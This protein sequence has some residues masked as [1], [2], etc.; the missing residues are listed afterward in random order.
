MILGIH[1][2][3][4][5]LLKVHKSCVHPGLRVTGSSKVRL[6]MVGALWLREVI[7]SS[8]ILVLHINVTDTQVTRLVNSQTIVFF[9]KRLFSFGCRFLTIFFDFLISILTNILV[10]YRRTI[11]HLR[12]WILPH[13]IISRSFHHLPLLDWTSHSAS[14]ITFIR[15]STSLA[16]RPILSIN[17]LS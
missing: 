11:D 6:I 12:L 2:L 3:L 15:F 4:M 14:L 7:E 9:I 17:R 8:Q 1:L 5:G 13:L 10:E 16:F